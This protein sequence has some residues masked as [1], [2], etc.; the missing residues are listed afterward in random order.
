MPCDCCK[1]ENQFCRCNRERCENCRHCAVH[2]ECRVLKLAPMLERPEGERGVCRSPKCRA[3]IWWRKTA[4]GKLCPYNADGSSHFT[5]CI[6]APTFH[7]RKVVKG[8]R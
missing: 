5:T 6:D 7:R 1:K 3:E 2:C 4:A 8:A